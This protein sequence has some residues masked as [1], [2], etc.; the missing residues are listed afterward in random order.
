MK[1]IFLAVFIL[2]IAAFVNVGAQENRKTENR[3]RLFAPGTISTGDEEFSLTFTP[4]GKTVYFTKGDYRFKYAAI[5]VSRL[6]NRRWT[7]P[8][9]APFSG[10]WRDID[11]YISPD[12]T[13]LFFASTRPI[14]GKEPRKD[15]DI[16]MMEKNGAGWGEPR[17]LGAEI[18]SEGNETTVALTSDGTFYLGAER[19]GGKGGRDLYRSKLTGGNFSKLEPLNDFFNTP[20]DDANQYV[21]PDGSYMIF[22]SSRP[23]PSGTNSLFISNHRNGEW[24]TPEPFA[25]NVINATGIMGPA[26]S[27]DGKYFV[28]STRSGFFDQPLAASLKYGDLI[29][30]IRMPG[31]GMGDIYYVETSALG[32]NAF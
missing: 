14:S 13:K 29:N 8:E 11:P 23:N 19:P 25:Q 26:I 10:R 28:Y 2:L 17:H 20:Q 22:S 12:G 16:W 21:A 1:K 15:F 3:P 31:N 6:K 5:L 7:E 24:T 32:I 18:N 27:P 30:K 4:D 9:V